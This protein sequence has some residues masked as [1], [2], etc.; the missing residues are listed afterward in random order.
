M[1]SWILHRLSGV[2][3]VIFI[4][5]HIEGMFQIAKGPEAFNKVM[6]MYNTPLF[7]VLEIF[8]FAAIM[9]HAVNGLRVILMDFASGSKY[10]KPLLVSTYIITGIVFLV[11]AYFLWT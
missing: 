2:G 8:L 3:L 9:F 11:G 4:I 7:K 10:P 6:A 1:L 5:I